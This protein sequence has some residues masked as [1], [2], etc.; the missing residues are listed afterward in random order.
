MA[1]SISNPTPAQCL[2]L[3]PKLND[4]DADI[5]YMSLNDLYS[6]LT[7]GASTF[8]TSEYHTSAKIIDG[9]IQAL[10]DQNGEVQNQ[11]IK[12]VG[13]L[14]LKLPADILAPFIH[15]VSNIKTT[16]SVD[17]SIP[18]T[19]L[20]TFITSFPSPLPGLPPP[21]KT[22]EAY[23]AISTVMIPRLLGYL[24]FPPPQ[25]GLPAPPPGMLE[26]G[27]PKGVNSDA[28]DV[29]VEI[30]RCFGPMLR[31][32]EKQALQKTLMT[33]LYDGR[34]GSVVK[35]KAVVAISI[36]CVYMQSTL[37]KSLVSQVIEAFKGPGLTIAKRRLLLTTIGSISRSV[38]QRLG[39]H[40]K[41][42]M[43]FVLTPL[44]EQEFQDADIDLEDGEPNVEVEELR[45]AAL[46]ALEGFL[47]CCSNDIRDFTNES[48]DAAVRYVSYDPNAAS[49]EDDEMDGAHDDENE[50]A[51]DG[52]E[53]DFEQ[54][55]AFSD[56]E[57]ASWKI[58]RCAAKA[59]FAIISTRSNGDLLE[60]GTLYDKIAPVLVKRFKEREENVR[61]EVI[62]T[63]A[64]LI[65]KTG[66]SSAV[67]TLPVIDKS[68]ATTDSRR[69][70]KRRRVDS[71]TEPPDAAGAF[72]VSLGLNSPAASPSPVSGPRAELARLNAAIVKGV[73]QLL[74]Q[75]SIPT[76]QT[77]ISLLRES[78]LV[79][80]GGL[81]DHLSKIIDPLLDIIRT[82]SN[83]PTGSSSTA[84]G[85]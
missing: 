16:H 62:V 39:P 20:R 36:L 65:K 43:P 73:S 18:T 22:S 30:I 6:L 28:V 31:D 75:S 1:P 67:G 40:A 24:V 78:V 38:P 42:L 17:T 69:S 82:A 11:A 8:L 53:E 85:G 27:S 47:T 9:I 48:I 49:D 66:E 13:A 71:T 35:K 74:K 3:L 4:A 59:L 63:L 80:N 44:S 50:D 81:S 61:L 83:A 57:D 46:V 29:L 14:V 72:A 5:R 19:A 10:D 68:M 37:L 25:V 70:R 26:I 52:G 79:Q 41:S 23:L 58:R 34:T 76:R 45:E 12:C 84:V 64:L 2:S 77:A 33:I 51:Y 21:D 7:A 32:A 60:S 55:V 54:D 15:R 56:D